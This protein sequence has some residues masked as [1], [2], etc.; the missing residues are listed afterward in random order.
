LNDQA[1]HDPYQ[2]L[3]FRDFRLL[4]IGNLI[5]SL[6]G[7]MLSLAIGWELYERTNSALVLGIVGLVQVIPI[8]LFSLVAGFVADRYNRKT[9]VVISQL[10]LVAASLGLTALSYWNGSLLLIYGCLLV[11]GTGTAFNGPASKTLPVEVV[12]EEAFENSATWSSSSWQLAAV[13]GPP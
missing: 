11:I 12:P 10:V 8:L 3:R 5:A 9:I 4:W 6:G 2:A 1:P 7:Q 13:G